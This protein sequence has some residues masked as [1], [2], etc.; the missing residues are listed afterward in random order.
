MAT[1]TGI[2]PHIAFSSIVY[3]YIVVLNILYCS[4]WGLAGTGTWELQVALSLPI[5]G[6]WINSGM[7]W[8]QPAPGSTKS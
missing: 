5:T 7:A 1:Y 6:N 3:C 2:S 4:E 8:Y